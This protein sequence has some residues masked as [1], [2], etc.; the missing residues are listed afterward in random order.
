[1]VPVSFPEQTKVLERPPSMSEKECGEL[2][3]WSDGTECISKW[4]MSWKE[5]W[6]CLFN[7]FVWVRIVFGITQPPVLIEAH[8]E[9]FKPGVLIELEERGDEDNSA[10]T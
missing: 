2:P 10:H 9:M 5:R 1:M 4:Q 8:N 6:H 7:G 3:V